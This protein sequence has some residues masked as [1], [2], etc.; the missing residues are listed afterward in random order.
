MSSFCSGLYLFRK[1]RSTSITKSSLG[2][3]CLFCLSNVAMYYC[4]LYTLVDF[5]WTGTAHSVMQRQGLLPAW[6]QPALSNSFDS[7]QRPSILR[8]IGNH[9]VGIISCAIRLHS[10]PCC[11]QL[12]PRI[13]ATKPSE[14]WQFRQEIVVVILSF[15]APYVLCEGIR[16]LGERGPIRSGHLLSPCAFCW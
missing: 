4:T 9:A 8:A 12:Y 7:F 16:T 5:G 2:R 13:L 14:H 11:Q 1:V 3:F 10:M 15:S 6:D